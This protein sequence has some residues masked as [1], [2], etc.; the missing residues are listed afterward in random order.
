MTQILALPSVKTLPPPSDSLSFHLSARNRH[1]L[2]KQGQNSYGSLVSVLQRWASGSSSSILL[3]QVKSDPKSARDFAVD[4]IQTVRAA[5]VP[6][7]W[8]LSASQ[9]GPTGFSANDICR[10]LLLQ[11]VEVNRSSLRDGDYSLSSTDFE[12]STPNGWS[13]VLDRALRGLKQVYILVD[14]DLLKYISSDDHKQLIEILRSLSESTSGGLMKR[15]VII[16]ARSTSGKSFGDGDYEKH[17]L[18]RVFTDDG[19][20]KFKGPA[21]VV[22]R[23]RLA[24]EGP[25][26]NRRKPS[27]VAVA[28]KATLASPQGSYGGAASGGPESDSD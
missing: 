25:S 17:P 13:A 26:S 22:R 28:L 5:D 23:K 3:A 21:K 9:L 6:V 24:K 14:I 15:K 2:R 7:I 10:M 11:A 16:I 19:S 4:L 8:A 12:L 1:R 18:T 20:R 27:G